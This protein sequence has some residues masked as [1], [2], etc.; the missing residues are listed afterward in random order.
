VA[1]MPSVPQRPPPSQQT[2]LPALMSRGGG[3]E[4]AVWSGSFLP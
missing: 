2:V 1:S 4:G 3:V